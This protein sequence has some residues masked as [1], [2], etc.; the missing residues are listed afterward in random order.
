MKPRLLAIF[1]LI[2]LVPLGLLIW[3]G[4]RLA[5]DEQKRARQQLS[6]V[7]SERLVEINN[8]ILN[9]LEERER[10]FAR[11]IDLSKDLQIEDWREIAKFS[12]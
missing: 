11:Q 12:C 9:I 1:L 3:I 5:H 6:D 2:V 10:E 8:S 4:F 7:Y